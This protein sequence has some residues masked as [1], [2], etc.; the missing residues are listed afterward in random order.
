MTDQRTPAS[1]DDLTPWTAFVDECEK[2]KV[3]TKSQLAWWC[4]YRETNGLKA[5]G[6]VIE[7][8]LSPNS[9]RPRLYANRS[10]FAGW[11]STSDIQEQAA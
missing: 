1:L 7:K 9:K 8:R 4:R 10:R 5:S 11:L 3:A 6:A 2:K